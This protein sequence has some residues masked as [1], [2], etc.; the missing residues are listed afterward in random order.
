L[1]LDDDL[2]LKET[3]E[4]EDPLILLNAITG[5]AGADTMQLAVR[6][7]DQLLGALVDSSSTHSFISVG[8]ASRLYLDPLPLPGLHVKVANG[9]RVATAGICRKTRIYIDS[10]EFVIDLFIIPVDGYDMVLGV[11]WLRTL[12]PI[13]WDFAHNHMSCWCDDHRVVW[14][15]TVRRHI[16]HAMT[17]TNLMGLL[18]DEF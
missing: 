11:H 9:D 18:L 3:I 6:M 13:L 12:G 14:Q 17:A 15:G 1:Q 10:K 2:P 16:A 5:L 4:T 7:G 8:A